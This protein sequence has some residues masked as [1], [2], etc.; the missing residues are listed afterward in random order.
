MK[1]QTQS[2]FLNKGISTPAGII[3]VVLAALL[4]GGVLAWQCWWTPQG[5]KEEKEQEI[6]QDETASWKTYT[7]EEYG[8]EFK[9]PETVLIKETEDL[10]IFYLSP[11]V[12]VPFW[13]PFDF[14][15]E[16][17]VMEKKQEVGGKN[18]ELIHDLDE[19]TE[20][21]KKDY[22][23]VPETTIIRNDLVALRIYQG[24]NKYLRYNY[25][26]K[27]QDTIFLISLIDGGRGS[28]SPFNQILSTFK[29][30]E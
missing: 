20:L 17:M 2:K 19:L 5:E 11:K 18:A 29:F 24:T 4:A 25:Y 6:A 8:F 23:Y 15:S 3:I 16:G 26:I 22:I 10:V 7:N 30:L 1:Q 27:D 21:L 9:Y 13:M 28:F 12:E 14:F